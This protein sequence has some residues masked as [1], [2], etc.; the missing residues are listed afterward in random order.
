MALGIIFIFVRAGFYLKIHTFGPNEFHNL[1][2][3]FY[4]GSNSFNLFFVIFDFISVPGRLFAISLLIF[5]NI[6][7]LT[8]QI[9]VMNFNLGHFLIQIFSITLLIPFFINFLFATSLFW[10]WVEIQKIHVILSIFGFLGFH[11][12]ILKLSIFIII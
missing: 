7:I 3:H 5:V 1:L 12:Q 2:V 9:L 10:K 8:H 4:R 11:Y 6:N